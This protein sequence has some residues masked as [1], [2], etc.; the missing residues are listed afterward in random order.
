M[1]INP[2]YLFVTINLVFTIFAIIFHQIYEKFKLQKS[3]E[4]F[5]ILFYFDLMKNIKN[6]GKVLIRKK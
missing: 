3:F 2:S 5:F 4:N 6:R 1:S